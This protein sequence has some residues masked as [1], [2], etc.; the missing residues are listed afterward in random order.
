MHPGRVVFVLARVMRRD[1]YDCLRLRFLSEQG[2]RDTHDDI[3]VPIVPFSL[4]FS[5]SP[6]P[7]FRPAVVNKVQTDKHYL[8]GYFV[9]RS[10]KPPIL[11]FYIDF[12]RATITYVVKL[13]CFVVIC[14]TSYSR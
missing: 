14:K 12:I 2:R 9:T 7:R 8:D 13:F 4:A 1:S 10:S 6:V 3:R 5:I 11:P